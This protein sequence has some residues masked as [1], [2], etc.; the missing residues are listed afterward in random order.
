M[1]KHFLEQGLA[2][3]STGISSEFQESLQDEDGD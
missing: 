3:F 2:R 1:R